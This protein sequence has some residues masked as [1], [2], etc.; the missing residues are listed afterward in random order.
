MEAILRT[1]LIIQIIVHEFLL[2]F[3]GEISH[4]QQIIILV[5]I[6]VSIFNISLPRR[7]CFHRH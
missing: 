6:S 7:L 4:E 3:E 5:V 2:F 1:L